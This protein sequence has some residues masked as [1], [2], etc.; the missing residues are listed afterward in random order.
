MN[1]RTEKMD[2]KLKR[3]KRVNFE[4]GSIIIASKTTAEDVAK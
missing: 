1:D 4:N 2:E 3:K